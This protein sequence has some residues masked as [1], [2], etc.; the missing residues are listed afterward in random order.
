MLYQLLSDRFPF[1]N[2]EV[3]QMDAL[4]PHALRDGILHGVP[5]FGRDPWFTRVHPSAQDLICAML[6]RDVGSRLTA[7]E[8]LQHPW[9][10]HALSSSQ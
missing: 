5:L 6:R 4:G 2:L 7:A 9:F 10:E 8:A 3:H 1:W